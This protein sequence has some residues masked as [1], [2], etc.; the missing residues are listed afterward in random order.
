MPKKEGTENGI[1]ILIISI[2]SYHHGNGQIWQDTSIEV[3]LAPK[4]RV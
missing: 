1:L 2:L 3:I 4:L